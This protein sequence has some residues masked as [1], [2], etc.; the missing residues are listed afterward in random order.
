MVFNIFSHR[1]LANVAALINILVSAFMIM[2]PQAAHAAGPTTYRLASSG[3]PGVQAR[4]Y[5]LR[6][7]G[8]IRS[9]VNWP[10]RT[11]GCA[12]FGGQPDKTLPWQAQLPGLP[13]YN[14]NI[15]DGDTMDISNDCTGRYHDAGT[16]TLGGAWINA[17]AQGAWSAA[18]VQA[19]NWGPAYPSP[20]SVV[21]PKCNGLSTGAAPPIWGDSRGGLNPDPSDQFYTSGPVGSYGLTPLPGVAQGLFTQN[22]P[23]GTPDASGLD[24]YSNGV[25]LF[26]QNFTLT[27]TDIANLA[28]PGSQLLVEGVADDFFAVYINGVMTKAITTS[29]I[30]AK[31]LDLTPY[32]PLL[33]LTPGA[34]NTLG[35]M[36]ADKA[37]FYP[38]PDPGGRQVGSC[39]NLNV[40]F[41]PPPIVD[42]PG[43]Q[44][45]NGDVHAG[46]GIG[47]CTAPVAGGQITTFAGS[48]S[49]SQYVVSGLTSISGL[50]SNGA[51]ADTLKLGSSGGYNVVCRPDLIKAAQALCASCYTPLASGTVNINGLGSGVYMVAGGPL[52]INCG[53]PCTV[54]N[55]TTIVVL[56]GALTISSPI[57]LNPALH[58]IT[59][60]PALGVIT[61][62]NINIAGA[63]KRVDAYLFSSGGTIDTCL[64]GTIAACGGAPLTV[65]GFLMAHDISFARMGDSTINGATQAEIVNL[66]PIIYL[67]PPA[68]F[69]GSVDNNNLEGQGERSPLF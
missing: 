28:L 12:P 24:L 54:N 20:S 64:E 22:Y 62:G 43:I 15:M 31:T 7:Y 8:T 3:D 21:V 9:E 4:W 59:T 30:A 67:K 37:I 69:D 23:P 44:A 5:S 17:N 29:A 40:T 10:K 39:Y 58:T 48:N 55:S 34:T 35:I 13:V 49:A 66:N 60:L 53:G 26:R 45:N 57:Q 14:G 56:N 18:G 1:R 16:A 11:E 42:K 25:S 63:V 47:D 36:D 33:N 51:G 65:N 19:A 46:G 2:P 41:T 68:L 50:K 6:G 38:G 52:N 61:S 27:A 32:V